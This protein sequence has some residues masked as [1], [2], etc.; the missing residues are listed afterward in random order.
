M[1]LLGLHLWGQKKT[2]ENHH[3]LSIIFLPTLQISTISLKRNSG[4][5]DILNTRWERPY[6]SH[7]KDLTLLLTLNPVGRLNVCTTWFLPLILVSWK[8]HHF[9]LRVTALPRKERLTTPQ[10]TFFGGF[11]TYGMWL[12]EPDSSALKDRTGEAIHYYASLNIN[13]EPLGRM[14]MCR[15][16]WWSCRP[17]WSIS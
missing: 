10:D 14:C 8:H 7:K 17:I 5:G 1:W 9:A 6:I 15:K 2:E 3:P 4:Q 11:S 12:T 16:L 13:C